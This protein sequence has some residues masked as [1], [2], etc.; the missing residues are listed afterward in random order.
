MHLI[1]TSSG[2]SYHCHLNS[3][4]VAVKEAG[5]PM[6]EKQHLLTSLPDTGKAGKTW[7]QGGAGHHAKRQIAG[8]PPK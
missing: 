5:L 1:S 8:K 4:P 3:D 6:T 7:E 2:L